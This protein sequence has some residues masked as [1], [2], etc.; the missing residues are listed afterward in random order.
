MNTSMNSIRKPSVTSLNQ[1]HSCFVSN[2]KYGL[3]PNFFD[4]VIKMLLFVKNGKNQS[5]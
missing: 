1:K 3:Y 4:S 2:Q 5:V